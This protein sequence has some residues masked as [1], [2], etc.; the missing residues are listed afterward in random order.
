MD[1]RI[2][3]SLGIIS[4]LTLQ[5]V[6]PDVIHQII[7]GLSLLQFITL[8]IKGSVLVDWIK[9]E[10]WRDKIPFY[11]I[12]CKKHGYQLNYPSGFNKVLI[13]PKCIKEL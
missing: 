4:A 9:L 6:N 1:S 2:L 5:Q 13:C 8:I 7:V 10:G 12:K 3:A 11:L